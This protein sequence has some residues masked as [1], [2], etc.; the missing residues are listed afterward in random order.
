MQDETQRGRTVTTLAR[1]LDISLRLLHPFTPF[2]T[3]ELWG[4]LRTALRESPLA[5]LAADWPEALIVAGWPEGRPVEDW[6]EAKLADFALV[7]EIVRSIR[8]LRAEKNVAPT[9]KLQAS[10]AA[11]PKTSMLK[12][13]AGAMAA[14]AG[15]DP[16]QLRIAESP[17]KSEAEAVA[18]VIGS[19]E[20]Q[21]PLAGMVDFAGRARAPEEGT[22]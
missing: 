12:D 17:A 8:N 20:I 22:L 9:R 11:G 3:E 13:Q 14:L 16:A 18:L 10:M 2:I 1:V 15:L 6:E 7:Q 19:V 5:A 4:H 21:L